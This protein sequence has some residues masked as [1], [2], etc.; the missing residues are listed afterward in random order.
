MSS[1]CRSMERKM[2]RY[3]VEKEN[4]AKR[5]EAIKK[6]KKE[7]DSLG[8]ERNIVLFR[9][10]WFTNHHAKYFKEDKDNE[11]SVI[12]RKGDKGNTKSKSRRN[13][14]KI[15]NLINKFRFSVLNKKA[16]KKK[17][18]KTVTEKEN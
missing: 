1:L 12:K 16:S 5:T 15:N 7:T 6:R 13:T 4:A 11:V 3:S 9:K 18:I 14:Q 17:A 10:A 8:L 2:L